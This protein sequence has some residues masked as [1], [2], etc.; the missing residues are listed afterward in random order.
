MTDLRK[1][2]FKN[3]SDKEKL[4]LFE[5]KQKKDLE[6]KKIRSKLEKAYEFEKNKSFIMQ[7]CNRIFNEYLRQIDSFL[8][9]HL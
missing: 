3:E 1:E 8:F 6:E 7:K 2:M 5:W 9:Q 4:S